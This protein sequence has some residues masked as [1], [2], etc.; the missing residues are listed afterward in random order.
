MYLHGIKG[1]LHWGFNFY[2]SQYSISHI[3]PFFNTHASYAF[4]SGD[5][6]LVYPGPDEKPMSSIRA[7]VQREALDDLNALTT[8]ESVVGR[9]RV[10]AL[11]MENV[12]EPFDFEHYPHLADYIL[13]L[14]ERMAELFI[15]EGQKKLS[16][17]YT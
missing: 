4:P 17:E 5:A 16:L 10:V 7:Q 15:Q 3:D 9:E 8:L 2:N 6:F 1:F 12:E 13:Q 14:R 11:I